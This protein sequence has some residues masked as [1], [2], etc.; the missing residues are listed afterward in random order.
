LKRFV[1]LPRRLHLRGMQD[2]HP[3]RVLTAGLVPVLVH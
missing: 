3:D 1:E 2:G